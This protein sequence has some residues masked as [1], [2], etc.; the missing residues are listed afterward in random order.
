MR[1][2]ARVVTVRSRTSAIWVGVGLAALVGP[3]AC[4]P[5]AEPYGPC[6]VDHPDPE[7]RAYTNDL[8][9]EVCRAGYR[10]IG[11]EPPPDPW[12]E[13]TEA[14]AEEASTEPAGDVTT[15]AAA[16]CPQATDCVAYTDTCVAVFAAVG[17]ECAGGA[18]V[19]DA[20]GVCEVPDR[21]S[22]G[23]SCSADGEC[24]EGHCVDGICCDAACDG[25]CQQC[26]PEGRCN[27]A[28]AAA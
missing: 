17:S 26:S 23:A 2:Q 14:E 5:H 21:A 20:A 3:V 15:E 13:E 7:Y 22:L 16:L 6:V 1:R 25:V 18:G 9:Q 27:V 8:G 12:T 28:P 11:A 10:Q 4:Q 24:A 19:C